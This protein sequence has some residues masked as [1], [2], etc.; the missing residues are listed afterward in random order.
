M[1]T[2]LNIL[3]ALHGDSII[4]ETYDRN[5][6][7]FTILIDGGPRETFRTT[8][9]H[10]L[11][12]YKKIDLIILTHIDHDHISG[13]IHYLS[14]SYAK[15]HHFDKLLLN[16]PNLLKVDTNG[17]QI[18]IDEGIEFKSLIHSQYPNLKIISEVTSESLNKLDL[19][20]G[21][22]I[23]ILSPN[24]IALDEL[25]KNW[26]E[27]DLSEDEET[28]IASIDIIAKDFNVNFESLANNVDIEKNIKNDFANA[29]SIAFSI[30]TFD[31]HG[32]FLGDAHSTIVAEGLSD[33]YPNQSPIVFDYVKLSHHGSKYNISNRFLD[34]IECY[35]YIISTNGGKGG[36]KHP[37]RQTIAKI[38]CHTNMQKSKVQFYFNYPL[39]DI[40]TRTGKLFKDEEILLFVCHNKNEFTI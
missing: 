6:N 11:S 17:T 9:V 18:S 3:K 1:K 23:K 22:D 13:L 39:S 33:K 28:Q 7:T 15:N 32:L 26:S 2:K 8:L 19:P 34:T 20:D 27:I 25:N 14:S 24:Q 21:I 40:E 16:S 29:S 10:E 35:N 36:T 12:R 38:V 31:F 4:I 30:Q 5:K 37:D